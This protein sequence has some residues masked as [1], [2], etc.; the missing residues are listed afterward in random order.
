MDGMLVLLIRLSD[1]RRPDLAQPLRA[2]Q[3]GWT[4]CTCATIV[5]RSLS[6][7]NPP[8]LLPLGREFV[9]R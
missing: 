4:Y 2:R 9:R 5:A 3:R 1:D 6:S 7:E 8:S